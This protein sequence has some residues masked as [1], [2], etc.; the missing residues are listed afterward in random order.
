MGVCLSNVKGWRMKKSPFFYGAGDTG[1]SQLKSLV[2]RI[3]GKGN[4][5]SIDLKEMEARF[6]TGVI[7][8]MR[9]AGSSDMSFLSIDELKTFKK[10]TGG[11]SIFAE[12]KFQQGFEFTYTGML[13]F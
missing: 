4:F 5:V 11:D 10:V 9:L 6:G 7:Y 12:F 2:E 8:G 1:K 13:W 3:L